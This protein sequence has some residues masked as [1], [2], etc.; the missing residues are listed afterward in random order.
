VE[1]PSDDIN[2]RLFLMN[3]KGLRSKRFAAL[4]GTT[5]FKRD[6]WHQEKTPD[7]RLLYKENEAKRRIP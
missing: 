6:N 2:S 4:R 5:G 7:V 1:N 3:K